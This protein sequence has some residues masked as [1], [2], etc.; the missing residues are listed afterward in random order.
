MTWW[1]RK[2]MDIK[3]VSCPELVLLMRQQIH[4]ESDMCSGSLLI[5]LCLCGKPIQQICGVCF[6]SHL[7][8]SLIIHKILFPLKNSSRPG[9]MPAGQTSLLA[10]F[11]GQIMALIWVPALHYQRSRRLNERSNLQWPEICGNMAAVSLYVYKWLPV[12]D[13]EY[14]IVFSPLKW[15]IKHPHGLN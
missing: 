15:E 2:G 12:A 1:E 10:E 13:M 5:K 9:L 14:L 6:S 4:E 3:T 7:F 8:C 11:P